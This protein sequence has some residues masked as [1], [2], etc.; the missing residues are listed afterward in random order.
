[1]LTGNRHHGTASHHGYEGDNAP[2]DVLSAPSMQNGAIGIET[3]LLEF[4]IPE[5]DRTQ[6][7]SEGRRE[8]EGQRQSLIWR[9]K[10]KHLRSFGFCTSDK[11]DA[12]NRRDI[13][14]C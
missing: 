2:R 8:K 7:C 13:P 10:Q 12:T 11:D 6:H 9:E 14:K 3:L 5:P 1:M 4:M